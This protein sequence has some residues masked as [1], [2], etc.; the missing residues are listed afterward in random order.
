M[1]L[2]GH[3][4]GHGCVWSWSCIVI[5]GP[6]WSWSCMDKCVHVCSCMVV[7]GH[8][9]SSA[10]KIDNIGDIVNKV[11]RGKRRKIGKIDSKG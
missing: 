5:Y 6:V 11:S 4:H 1:V 7:C 10:G 8:M 3:G 2:Y 9:R